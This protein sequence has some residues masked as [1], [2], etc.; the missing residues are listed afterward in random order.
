[1]AEIVARA[2]RLAL[3]IKN[4]EGFEEEPEIVF[5]FHE[6]PDNPCSERWVVQQW[7]RANGYEISEW[8]K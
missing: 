4:K 7:F 2:E 6:A 1:M 3:K 8:R 5:L